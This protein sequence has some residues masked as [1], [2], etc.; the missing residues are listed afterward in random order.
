[1]TK[2]SVAVSLAALLTLMVAWSVGKGSSKV[3]ESFVR[4]RVVQMDE[5][6]HPYLSKRAR[7]SV[8]VH[9]RVVVRAGRVQ[10]A[11]ILR[12]HPLLDQ[13]VEDFLM[14]WR[15]KPLDGARQAVIEA[16]IH[17]LFDL[18]R[19]GGERPAVA[20]LDDGNFVVE[21]R[22]DQAQ[23]HCKQRW[24]S[25]ADMAGWLQTEGMLSPDNILRLA[26]VDDDQELVDASME[27]LKEAGVENINMISAVPADW[28]ARVQ[29]P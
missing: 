26:F 16:P 6:V 21:E 3:S 20:V 10:S 23:P 22:E 12:G 4:S 29:E 27:L 25:R 7:F 8:F 17:V 28:H 11:D 1:M 5:L 13:A 19:K 15:L 18:S 24:I 2:R 9:A 14:S